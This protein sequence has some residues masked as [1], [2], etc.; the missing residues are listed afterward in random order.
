MVKS[1]ISIFVIMAMAIFFVPQYASAVDSGAWSADVDIAI[2][3]FSGGLTKPDALQ[4][5]TPSS[6]VRMT[7]LVSTDYNN[8]NIVTQHS[9][10]D[11]QY[12][13]HSNGGRMFVRT[14]TTSGTW[15][16]TDAPGSATSVATDD[17]AGGWAGM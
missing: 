13:L 17:F 8:Y 5:F 10:G 12:G 9:G 16:T 3:T 11:K 7:F 1:L 2:G 15:D 6:G 4:T 14:V